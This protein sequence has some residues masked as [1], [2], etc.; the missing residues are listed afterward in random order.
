M[1]SLFVGLSVCRF[2]D[3]LVCR[4]VDLLVGCWLV[5]H[6]F[7]FSSSLLPFVYFVSFVVNTA[8]QP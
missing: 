7:F 8:I 5:L 2:V 1:P 6:S 3:L 4:F